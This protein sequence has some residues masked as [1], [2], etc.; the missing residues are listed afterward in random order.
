MSE[1]TPLPEEITPEEPSAEELAAV[2]RDAAAVDYPEEERTGSPVT[3]PTP[4]EDEAE[5]DLAATGTINQL[6]AEDTLQDHGGRDPLDEAIAPPDAP[7]PLY[8]GTIEDEITPDSI[9]ERADAEEPEVWD[10][11]R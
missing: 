4:D 6:P 10:Q 7:G 9:E 2:D 3:A 5:P 8:E 11:D 1:S